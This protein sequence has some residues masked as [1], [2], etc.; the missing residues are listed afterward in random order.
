MYFNFSFNSLRFENGISDRFLKSNHTFLFFI[1]SISS[2]IGDSPFNCKSCAIKN[3]SCCL[4][5]KTSI[6]T[7]YQLPSSILKKFLLYCWSNFDL[8]AT[9][10]Q[11]YEFC[12]QRPLCR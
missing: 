10:T 9:I 8:Y 1:K 6:S 7:P 4:L 2:K 3:C 5:K 12:Q 11:Y